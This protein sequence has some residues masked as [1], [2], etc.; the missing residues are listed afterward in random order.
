MT[1]QSAGDVCSPV[2]WQGADPPA[3][4]DRSENLRLKIAGPFGCGK[5][6]F[7]AQEATRLVVE[8]GLAPESICLVVQTPLQQSQM[9]AWL[10]E[11]WPSAVQSQNDSTNALESPLASGVY[12]QEALWIALLDWLPG[13]APSAQPA[14]VKPQVKAKAAENQPEAHF[15]SAGGKYRVLRPRGARLLLQSLLQQYP[16]PDDRLRPVLENEGFVERLYQCLAAPTK[17]GGGLVPSQDALWQWAGSSPALM[18]Q[19]GW[20]EKLV[21]QWQAATVEKG[22]LMPAMVLPTLYAHCLNSRLP[23]SNLPWSNL[24]WQAVLIDDAHEWSAEALALMQALTQHGKTRWIMA[25]NDC[26]ESEFSTW[27]APRLPWTERPVANWRSPLRW[28]AETR[29]DFQALLAASRAARPENKPAPDDTNPQ[30]ED[31]LFLEDEDLRTFFSFGYLE[32]PAQEYDAVADWLKAHWVKNVADDAA[33]LPAVAVLTPTLAQ[34]RRWQQALCQ[35]GLLQRGLPVGE[36]PFVA[37]SA[38]AGSYG[39]KPEHKINS[40]LHHAVY[41]LQWLHSLPTSSVDAVRQGYFQHDN[42]PPFPQADLSLVNRS[43]LWLL[44]AFLEGAAASRD[45]RFSAHSMPTLRRWLQK[46]AQQSERFNE[47]LGTSLARAWQSAPEQTGPKR[48]Q[49]ALESLMA[50]L[51]DA[52][53]QQGPWQPTL[54]RV[55]GWAGCF[56]MEATTE[57]IQ[58]GLPPVHTKRLSV[59]ARFLDRLT[60]QE[61]LYWQ[62]FE[63]PMPLSLLDGQI[64][65]LWPTEVSLHSKHPLEISREVLQVLPLEAARGLTFDAVAL[66]GL[67]QPPLPNPESSVE[68][69]LEK[70]SAIALSV[71][72]AAGV[73][74]AK[75]ACLLTV[76][77]LDD[78]NQPVF[79]S[80]AYRQ[81]WQAVHGLGLQSQDA[82]RTPALCPCDAERMG[83][84]ASSLSSTWPEAEADPPGTVLACAMLF[85]QKRFQSPVASASFQENVYRATGTA[86]GSLARSSVKPMACWPEAEILSLSASGLSSF[87]QCPR[88]FYYS[89]LLSLPQPSASAATLGKLVHS[90]LEVFNRQYVAQGCVPTYY[91]PEQLQQTVSVLSQSAE[92][93]VARE[94]AMA[95]G[96]SEATLDDWLLLSPLERVELTQ[97]VTAACHDLAHKGFFRHPPTMVFSEYGFQDLQLPDLP[98]V[99]WQGRV[100]A[101]TAD[102]QNRWTLIDYKFYGPSEWKPKDPDRRAKQLASVL[103]EQETAQPQLRFEKGHYQL[104]LYYALLQ[105]QM[106]QQTANA[107]QAALDSPTVT[108]PT[109]ELAGVC[110]Q[111]VRPAFADDPEQGAV[112][113]SLDSARLEAGLPT[114][115]QD[116]NTFFWQPLVQQPQLTAKPGQ[117]CQSC[118]Y[119]QVCEAS[120]ADD[121]EDLASDGEVVANE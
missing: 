20:L 35:R 40:L 19:S 37:E 21:S 97:R 62:A 4:Q 69:P 18:A 2:P 83:L 106:R 91:T 14:E 74:L 90:I 52:C 26:V 111:V 103:G 11:C 48:L 25:G 61:Q 79:V 50:C 66:V 59:I 119:A 58:A 23:S 95:L 27:N 9:R 24:P 86:W 44:L 39:Q 105:Q 15:K 117:I 46:V 82:W 34:A 55:L 107:S 108:L 5:S 31:A 1:E 70:D 8:D 114:I 93:L 92:S 96:Y 49:T 10:A 89:R 3:A 115:M 7:L 81:L 78:R 100:D 30:T 22:L 109:G 41:L 64:D 76:S 33:L 47:W 104:P 84:A 75:K 72:L 88:Q 121:L 51:C 16:V 102:E 94:A 32:T 85:C 12:T 29:S 71:G 101:L 38:S 13:V 56:H 60:E 36:A 87:Q 17:A 28:N 67:S 77:R 110:L 80:P 54:W 68:T 6:R 116:L 65:A 113:I 53:L 99:L 120:V 57:A 98:G 42:P 118:A 45:S 63:Q 73:A 43:L 112:A